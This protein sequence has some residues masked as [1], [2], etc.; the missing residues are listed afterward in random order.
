MKKII[1]FIILSLSFVSCL[2]NSKV[3]LLDLSGTMTYYFNNSGIVYEKQN[4]NILSIKKTNKNYER[5]IELLNHLNLKKEVII[6]NIN[7]ENTTRTVNGGSF[8]R[9]YI[10]FNSNGESEI[11]NDTIKMKR[12]IW[13]PTHPDAIQE[14]P[15]KGYVEY[16]NI[17]KAEEL[18]DLNYL[19]NDLNIVLSV[20]KS[21]N[22]DLII[23]IEDIELFMD[24]L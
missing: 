10:E 4:N 12:L 14:G 21:F 17:N 20:L 19:N 18:I 2:N 9:K 13:D 3:E 16:P 5:F 1:I 11:I 24:N 7:N 8:S 6:N 15:N 23:K 22:P